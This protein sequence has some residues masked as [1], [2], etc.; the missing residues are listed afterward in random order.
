MAL[1]VWAAPVLSD[2]ASTASSTAVG[3]C[4]QASRQDFGCSALLAAQERHAEAAK[5]LRDVDEKLV[6]YRSKLGP[7]LVDGAKCAAAEATSLEANDSEMRL[8]GP[9]HPDNLRAARNHAANLALQ[10]HSA[11][12]E[13]MLR[14]VLA[15]QVRQLGAEHPETLSTSNLLAAQER[16]SEAAKMLRDVDEKLV[17]YRSKLGPDAVDGA[18]C[19]AAEATSLEANDSAMRL[20]G[21][22]HPDNLRAARNHAANLALQGHN[23]EA[24]EM[25]R[26]V[27]TAQVRQLGAEHPETLSTLNQLA[28]TLFRQEKRAAAEK[29]TREVIAAQKRLVALEHPLVVGSLA[30]SLAAQGKDAVAEEML[31]GVHTAQKQ[32]LGPEHAETLSTAYDLAACLFR[33]EKHAAAEETTREVLAVQTRRLGPQHP[34]TLLAA[35]GVTASLSAQGKDA[36]AEQML[37]A[38]QHG[39]APGRLDPAQPQALQVVIAG[40]HQFIRTPSS[41]KGPDHPDTLSSAES[42]LSCLATQ[43][44]RTGMD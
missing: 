26:G 13:E 39:E 7:D 14:T 25:L 31:R 12:A 43:D 42:L 29:M 32:K 18:K 8:L 27:H 21:P 30:A 35:G 20:L 34:E 41:L 5:M 11:E 4:M 28:E 38:V 33:Q 10:G 23:A 2:V 1:L 24:E 3:S 36:E 22:D 6:A 37:R 9:D 15:A 16:H 44:E 40:I 17:A 19:A